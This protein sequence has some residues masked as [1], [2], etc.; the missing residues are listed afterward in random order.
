MGDKPPYVAPILPQMC[1]SEKCNTLHRLL[2]F[3]FGGICDQSVMSLTPSGDPRPYLP[4]TPKNPWG[5]GREGCTVVLQGEGEGAARSGWEGATFD[6]WWCE[7]N[8]KR[9]RESF[10]QAR[11]TSGLKC[12]CTS[13]LYNA[14]AGPHITRRQKPRWEPLVII[15]PS[16]ARRVKLCR[17][18]KCMTQLKIDLEEMLDWQKRKLWVIFFFAL[19]ICCTAAFSFAF[20]NSSRSVSSFTNVDFY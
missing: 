13:P 17:S 16:A 18:R 10:Y 14:A 11:N 2:H 20:P 3:N 12:S 5:Q 4:Q 9:L 1:T 6:W 7:L 19:Q 8:R 15:A